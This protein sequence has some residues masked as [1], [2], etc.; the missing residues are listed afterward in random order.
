MRI[1]LAVGFSLIALTAMAA[2][3]ANGDVNLESQATAA[4]T[5]RENYRVRMNENV[6]T[7]MAGS[8]NGTDL[9]SPMIS[10]RSWTTETTSGSFPSLAKGPRR[11]SRT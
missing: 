6:V 2:P 7:I 3:R 11:A 5:Q 10:P 8:P 1:A 4:E 9:A